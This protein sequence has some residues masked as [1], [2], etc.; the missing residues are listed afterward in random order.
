MILQLSVKRCFFMIPLLAVLTFFHFSR[1]ETV[2]NSGTPDPPFSTRSM[3]ANNLVFF[4]K[5][6]GLFADGE[7][8]PG[9]FLK[10]QPENWL[11][12]TAGLFIGAQTGDSARVMASWF[13]PDAVPGAVDGSGQRYGDSDPRFRVYKIGIADSLRS[14]PDW[15]EWPE[16]QGA[17]VDGAWH[18]VLLGD[19]T[20]F[21]CFTDAQTVPDGYPPFDTD[22]L[23]AEVHLTVWGWEDVEDMVFLRWEIV[24]RSALSWKDAFVGIGADCELGWANDDQVGSDS[25]LSLVYVYNKDDVDDQFG[26]RPPSLG[27]MFLE[28]P[29]VPSAGDTAG[30]W[31]EVVPGYRNQPALSPMLLKIGD[32]FREDWKGGGSVYLHMQG[33]DT[34]GRP[35]IDPVTGRPSRWA[36]SGDPLTGTGWLDS[37]GYDR[38]FMICSGPFDLEPGEVNTMAA[39][40]LVG[41]GQDR[42][43]SVRKLK[44]LCPLAAG[45]YARP[46]VIDA[47]EISADPAAS[48]FPL[49]VVLVNPSDPVRNLEFTVR[50]DPSKVFFSGASPS[51]RATELPV[52]AEHEGPGLLR[53]TVQGEIPAG[54]GPVVDLSGGFGLDETFRYTEVDLEYASA[55]VPIGTA[56][57]GV[58]VNSR[59]TPARLLSPQDGSG[60]ESVLQTFRWTGS[61]DGDGDSLRYRFY[62]IGQTEPF[63]TTADTQLA[64]NGSTF[65]MGDSAYR[66]TVAAYDGFQEILSPDTF[67]IQV[68]SLESLERVLKAGSWDP[69]Q[70]PEYLYALDADENYLYAVTAVQEADSFG[71]YSRHRIAAYSLRDPASPAAL[72][73]SDIPEDCWPYWMIARSGVVYMASDIILLAVDFRDPALPG[74]CWMGSL[75]NP[76]ERIRGIDFWGD[77]LV[78]IQNYGELLTV[79]RLANPACP[80]KAGTVSLPFGP[81]HKLAFSG[82]DL[83]YQLVQDSGAGEI[84]I[85]KLMEDWSVQT[86]GRLDIGRSIPIPGSP[87]LVKDGLAYWV[88]QVLDGPEYAAGSYTPMRLRIADLRDPMLPGLAGEVL[89]TGEPAKLFLFNGYLVCGR[90]IFSVLDPDRPVQAGFSRHIENQVEVKWP[91]IYAVQSDS[92]TVDILNCGLISREIVFQGWQGIVRTGP[93]FP[94]PSNGSTSASFNLSSPS[95]VRLDIFNIRGQRVQSQDLG[96]R[97]AGIHLAVWDGKTARGIQAAAGV[98]VMCIRAGKDQASIKI[99]HMP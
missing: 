57:G 81:Y 80:A 54:N 26:A 47:A 87:F 65:F 88:E 29:S 1:A 13:S 95:E 49:P 96:N 10:E 66:W 86:A 43:D 70:D 21:C 52:H 39:A 63:C 91:W 79:Y 22:P 4:V 8:R 46:A 89:V 23:G 25:T 42:L 76:L 45:L 53:V 94:N 71:M 69:R 16:Y 27:F 5:N 77:R 93:A 9:M 83:F 55:S 75:E 84:R 62:W 20:L 90:E 48:A 59:P 31:R 60:L 73:K 50:T 44:N 35:M 32:L 30:A 12:F 38:R 58:T 6:N 41:R 18:P 85:F 28:T 51:G 97:D 82:T 14:G 3:D 33:L 74:L 56:S 78:L 37:R 2:L 34:E 17:P 61:G 68:P 15:D 64:I 98:Y 24:N 72:G 19:Q 7:Y 67:S 40:I 99:L 11:L 92:K 36:F